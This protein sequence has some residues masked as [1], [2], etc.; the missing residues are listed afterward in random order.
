[1]R[2]HGR[3]WF[4]RMC[5]ERVLMGAEGHEPKRGYRNFTG[6]LQELHR[7]STGALQE[8]YRSFTE[9]PQELYRSST[10][11]RSRGALQELYRSFA[12]AL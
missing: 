4:L 11:S 3:A 7:N 2:A 1:M 8:L 12:G 6:A 9:T 5:H 10:Y